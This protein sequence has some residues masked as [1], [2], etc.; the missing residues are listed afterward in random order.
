MTGN[1]IRFSYRPFGRR[2]TNGTV[3]YC[4]D[5]G[6]DAARAVIV[7]YTGRPRTASLAPGGKPLRCPD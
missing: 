4:D 3:T 2:S 1:R 7:S 6:A 5:R